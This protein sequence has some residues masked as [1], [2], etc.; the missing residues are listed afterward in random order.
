MLLKK[1]RDLNGSIFESISKMNK[2]L[3]KKCI[4]TRVLKAGGLGG[5]D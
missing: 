3:A 4:N 1:I 5:V 2:T